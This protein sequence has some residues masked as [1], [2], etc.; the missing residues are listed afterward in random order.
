MSSNLVD[1]VKHDMSKAEKIKYWRDFFTY[2]TIYTADDLEKIFKN[3][4]WLDPG[5]VHL[6]YDG[7][8]NDKKN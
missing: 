2:N 1:I 5:E 8:L 6:I 4:P 7:I 3:V